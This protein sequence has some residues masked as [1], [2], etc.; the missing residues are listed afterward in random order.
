MMRRTHST[1]L[2]QRLLKR[3]NLE[4][5]V[6]NTSIYRDLDELKSSDLASEKLPWWITHKE[7]WDFTTEID[8]SIQKPFMHTPQNYYQHLTPEQITQYNSHITTVMEWKKT[9]KVPGFTHRDYAMKRGADITSLLPNLAGIDE[10]GKSVLYWTGSP[11]LMDTTPTP[12]D[13]GCPKYEGTPEE[14]LRMIKAFLK[15]CG[16]SKVRA[17]PIDAKFKSVQPKFYAPNVPLVYESVDKPYST[18]NK[19]VI[20]QKMQWAI[21][22]STQGGNNLTAQGNNWIG[23]L[24]AAIYSGGPSDFIQIQAQRF[25]K[26]L[27]YN[28][29]V[30]GISYN[31]QSWPAMGV[32]SG[33]GELGRIQI[34]ISP[35]LNCD[36]AI[37][38]IITDLP[39]SLSQPIDA[40]IT[41]FCIKCGICA[42]ICPVSAI[43]S[44]PEPSW[45]IWSSDPSN[46]NLKPELFNNPGKKTWYLGHHLCSIFGRDANDSKCGL[47]MINCPFHKNN[48]PV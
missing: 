31:L 48:N 15:I 19:R 24:G 18:E 14:N 13:M 34:S 30:S 21:V 27:G 4:D 11:K 26:I 40:G 46:P 29:I 43:N 8:W 17:V 39:V 42:N 3:F 41:R 1:I 16:A 9:S 10:N 5:I 22:F 32:A 6:A 7:F 38:C 35:F 25:L 33:M 2:S 44:N 23:S 37:R 20:P 45:D 36:R 12:E 28:S 47:C